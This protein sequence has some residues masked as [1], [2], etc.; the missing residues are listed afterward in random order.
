M[1]P[2]TESNL[3]RSI[4]G[5]RIRRQRREL[6]ISQTELARRVGISASYM[7]LIEWNKRQI[8]GTLLRKIAES[9]DL[10]L[11][12][13]DGA[14]ENR[15]FDALNEIAHLPSLATLDIEDNQT[16]ELIGRFPGWARGVAALAR[17]EQEATSLAQT[18]SDRLS[19]DPF[20]GETVHRML[21][22]IAAV[23]SAAEILTDYTD[24]TPE[25]RTRFYAII[26]EESRVL[27]DVGEALAAY[28]D[29]VDEP[30]QTLTPLD[31][32]EALFDVNANRFENIETATSAF[33]HFLTDPHPVSRQAKARALV[34]EHLHPVIAATIGRHAQ[35]ETSTARARAQRALLDYA[36][37]AIL[38]PLAAFQHQAE[39][40]KYDIEA[41]ADAFSVDI[42]AVCQRLT[43][44]PP[45]SNQPRF[46]YYRANAA[47]ALIKQ[48]GLESLSIPRYA[49]ACPLWVLYRA[50]QSPEAVIRQRAIFPSGARFVFVARARNTGPT[51]F[52]K[53][54]QY[55]TDMIAM[56]EDD[57]RHTVYAPDPTAL[58]EEVGPSCRLCPRPNCVHRVEDPLSD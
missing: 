37:G 8:A 43:A 36:V 15:L 11:A 52:G 5:T 44:L 27:S 1:E 2:H 32:V 12:E 50:Q 29:K 42:E 31:E 3:D 48:V 13:L 34:D 35:I 17:S 46:G 30:N 55:V 14:A 41:L 9:L 20:L 4:V 6:G 23:R 28:L 58:V 38:M 10:E 7:N 22:R 53:P 39:I 19:N 26:N 21:T 51:G 47:G 18:L 25:E 56:P 24:T 49:P 16:G 54:R 57:A 33:T 45:A 40:L